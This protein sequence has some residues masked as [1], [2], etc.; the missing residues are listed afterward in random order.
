MKYYLKLLFQLILSPRNGWEDIDKAVLGEKARLTPSRLLT[1]GFYPLIAITALSVFMQAILKSHVVF[2]TLFMRAIITFVI[3]FISYFF[4]NFVMSVAIE[5]MVEGEYDEFRCQTFSLFT[6]GM[7]AVISI[8]INCLPITPLVLFFL[9][10]YVALVQWKGCEFMHIR[11]DRIGQFMM[12]AILGV[13][14]PP[15]IF[16]FVFSLIF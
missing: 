8:I 14:L 2:I 1:S 13:L 9:P 4:S 6:L 10:C 5:P 11:K 3:Y 15:Y 12:L 7:L 16:Y